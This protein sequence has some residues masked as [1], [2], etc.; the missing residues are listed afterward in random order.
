MCCVR[1][2][3]L[4]SSGHTCARLNATWLGSVHLPGDARRTHLRR[5]RHYPFTTRRSRAG[6]LP[7]S[8]DTGYAFIF[9]SL[10]FSSP[11]VGNAKQETKIG[12]SG[13]KQLYEPRAR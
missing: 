9:L 1:T 6:K 11:L 7:G 4:I 5:S 8:R 2:R 12:E 10:H 13:R 3:I